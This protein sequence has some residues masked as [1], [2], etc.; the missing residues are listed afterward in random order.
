M[1]T[2]RNLKVELLWLTGV[3]AQLS[4]LMRA[5]RCKAS[6]RARSHANP[7]R[8][9]IAYFIYINRAS[10]RL[11]AQQPGAPIV[12]L[13]G[14]WIFPTCRFSC[15]ISIG[16]WAVVRGAQSSWI[17]ATSLAPR[18]FSADHL[19]AGDAR[20]YPAPNAHRFRNPPRGV[21]EFAALSVR[22][23]YRHFLPKS[24]WSLA[25]Y[26]VF[27]ET[28][29]IYFRPKI[30][31]RR[32]ANLPDEANPH[33]PMCLDSDIRP[34]IHNSIF[35]LYAVGCSYRFVRLYFISTP[36]SEKRM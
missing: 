7:P 19:G 16:H 27:R 23:Q 24:P 22:K 33:P 14:L 29:A 3:V 32:W 10:S 15:S 36:S 28:W 25:A 11:N 2:N 34:V 20:I 17:L 4:I 31:V 35:Y 8:M 18:S 21:W 12:L 13:V 9:F 26:Q 5:H 30:H 1:Q 6:K